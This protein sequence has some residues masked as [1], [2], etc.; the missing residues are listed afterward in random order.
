MG[1]FQHTPAV[2]VAI[3]IA[4]KSRLHQVER[5]HI[6]RLVAWHCHS[7]LPVSLSSGVYQPIAFFRWAA[8]NSRADPTLKLVTLYDYPVHHLCLDQLWSDGSS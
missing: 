7:Y 3:V 5:H 1:I 4:E 8:V 2:S 6:H